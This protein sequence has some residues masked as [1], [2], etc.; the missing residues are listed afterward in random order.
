MC[1]SSK[2]NV[3]E[4]DKPAWPKVPSL[5]SRRTANLAT[6]QNS[7]FGMIF[8]PLNS[9]VTKKLMNSSVSVGENK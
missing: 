7:H 8:A 2:A 6:A 9:A 4:M 1:V 5:L 3:S